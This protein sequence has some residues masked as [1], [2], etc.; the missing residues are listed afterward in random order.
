MTKGIRSSSDALFASNVGM[1]ANP[2][3]GPTKFRRKVMDELMALH[4]ISVSSAATH[5]NHSFKKV[6]AATPELVIGLGRAEDKKG[7]RKPKAVAAAVAVVAGADAGAATEVAAGAVPG[8]ETPAVE[9]AAAEPAPVIPLFNVVKV[10]DGALVLGGVTQEVADALVAKAAANPKK[11]KLSI[12]PVAVPEAAAT[13][14]APTENLPAADT[15]ETAPAAETAQAP[16]ETE[17]A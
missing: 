17:A 13:E 1:I 12:L 9:Q 11:A 15:V 2:E 5:Y 14:D 6:K 7:G 8:A 16:Q 4:G 3:Q 10:K